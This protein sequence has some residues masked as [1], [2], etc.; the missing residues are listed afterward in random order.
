MDDVN[1]AMQNDQVFSET[2][3]L[4]DVFEKEEEWETAKKNDEH[5]VMHYLHKITDEEHINKRSKKHK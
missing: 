2:N 4:Y 3:T 1:S 5:P